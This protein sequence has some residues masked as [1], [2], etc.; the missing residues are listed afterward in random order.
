MPRANHSTTAAGSKRSTA[1]LRLRSGQ[2]LRSRPNGGSKVQGSK[3]KDG[4]MNAV[5]I[6]PVVPPLRLV[7]VVSNV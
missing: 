4:D 3:F 6:V 7:P 5:S 2:A 1:F